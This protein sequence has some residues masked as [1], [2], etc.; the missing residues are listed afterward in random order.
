MKRK[1]IFTIRAEQNRLQ[2]GTVIPRALIDDLFFWT[3]FFGV[4]PRKTAQLLSSKKASHLDKQLESPLQPSK[5]LFSSLFMFKD[6][7]SV[8]VL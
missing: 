4:Y 1:Y 2:S 8:S 6:L 5:H 7:D 3:V